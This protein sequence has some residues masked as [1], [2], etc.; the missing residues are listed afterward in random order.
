MLSLVPYTISRGSVNFEVPTSFFW[1]Q[2]TWQSCCIWFFDCKSRWNNNDLNY[3]LICLSSSPIYI[4]LLCYDEEQK[5]Q[6]MNE[7]I[8]WWFCWGKDGR[9]V[10][11]KPK[12]T[13]SI[14]GSHWRVQVNKGPWAPWLFL[15]ALRRKGICRSWGTSWEYSNTVTPIFVETGKWRLSYRMIEDNL[16]DSRRHVLP[17]H[18][19]RRYVA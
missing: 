18:G 9:W 5:R 12:N 2:E 3:H 11:I 10:T 15:N 8:R 17:M 14:D 6:Y 1:F 16:F 4:I 13:A 7:W 19:S